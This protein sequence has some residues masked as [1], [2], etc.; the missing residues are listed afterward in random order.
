MAAEFTTLD[1]LQALHRDLSALRE[2]RAE[3]AA[4]LGSNELIDVFQRELGKIWN[5]PEKSATERQT[6]TSG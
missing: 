6:V 3:Q 2:G 1:A 4:A 5:R